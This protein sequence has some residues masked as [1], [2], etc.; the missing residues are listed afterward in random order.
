MRRIARRQ[1]QLPGI[2]ELSREQEAINYLPA[3]G[4][5]LIVG[6]PGTGKTVL[7]LLRAR[8]FRQKGLDHR[9]LVYN[10]LLE[11]ASQ[12]LH[13]QV[14]S[15][16]WIRWFNGVYRGLFDES[17]PRRS[18][19]WADIHWDQVQDKW[20]QSDCP[21]PLQDR[22]LIIDEGQDMPPGF[23][24]TLLLLGAEHLFVAADQNQRIGDCNSSIEDIRMALDLQREEIHYLRDNFRQRDRGY[25]VA[26]LAREFHTDPASPPPRLPPQPLADSPDLPL[27]YAHN[28]ERYES[29]ELHRRILTRVYNRPDRLIGIFTAS[30]ES[31]AQ[32]L[33]ALWRAREEHPGLGFIPVKSY[34]SGLEDARLKEIHFDQGG[35]LVINAPSCKGLEFDE[36]F[37]VNLEDFRSAN[38]DTDI[39]RKRFYVMISRARERLFLLRQRER[40][41]PV[42]ELMPN[43]PE[44]LRRLP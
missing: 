28:R 31:R 4:C 37:I 39:T 25:P 44:L 33:K 41:C 5:H 27:L 42:L 34:F 13:P 40:P 14:H 35:I 9:F 32:W 23:Y 21:R 18:D 24:Q 17:P 1:Y 43:D 38:D 22:Y 30:D 10:R 20:L 2:E 36:V 6:G 19:D 3:E 16:R 29:R 15:D 8:L 11:W 26:R 12:Q 7:A